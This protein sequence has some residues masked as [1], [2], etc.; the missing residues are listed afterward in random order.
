MLKL[1]RGFTL[2]ENWIVTKKATTN[3][4]KKGDYK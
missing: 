1:N 4:N 3:R 2:S